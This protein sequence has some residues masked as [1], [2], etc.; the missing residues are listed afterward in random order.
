MKKITI[1]IMSFLLYFSVTPKTDEL[2]I[3]NDK[4]I[5]INNTNDV[6]GLSIEKTNLKISDK[7]A[8][9]LSIGAINSLLLIIQ[10]GLY[11]T[12]DILAV[13]DKAVHM[14]G[15]GLKFINPFNPKNYKAF[16][17]PSENVYQIGKDEVCA[18]APNQFYSSSSIKDIHELCIKKIAIDKDGKSIE[19]PYTC[20]DKFYI[21]G[22]NKL[23][24]KINVKMGKT[25]VVYITKEN[26]KYKVIATKPINSKDFEN[27]QNNLQ[28]QLKNLPTEK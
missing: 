4:L 8:K 14:G 3:I 12:I 7:I 9:Q 18:L 21:N 1:I 17:I 26:N 16:N 23:Q 22:E 25:T 28:D 10:A 19:S 11:T 20:F 27:E 24:N 2:K 6:I 13:L 15:A 5:I